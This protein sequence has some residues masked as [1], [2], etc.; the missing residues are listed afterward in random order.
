MAFAFWPIVRGGSTRNNRKAHTGGWG[1]PRGSGHGQSVTY[2]TEKYWL[3][4]Q[5]WMDI[6]WSGPRK[7]RGESAGVAPITT[8]THSTYT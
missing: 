4:V 7:G 5:Y 8:H 3:N 2:F 1:A 6:Q